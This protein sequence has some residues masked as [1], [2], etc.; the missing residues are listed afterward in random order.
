MFIALLFSFSFI[1]GLD[2]FQK[3]P[4]KLHSTL[5]LETL[6]R[7]FLGGQQMPLNMK[8]QY[9]TKQIEKHQNQIIL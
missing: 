6:S 2:Q 7:V 4:Q 3:N 9:K 8:Q 1:L 5:W